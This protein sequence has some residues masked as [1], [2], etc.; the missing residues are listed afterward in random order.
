MYIVS[1]SSQP[2]LSDTFC[3]GDGAEGAGWLLCLFGCSSSIRTA[4]AEIKKGIWGAGKGGG[5]GWV[6]NWGNAGYPKQ[7]G[8]IYEIGDKFLYQKHRLKFGARHDKGG[9]RLAL[10]AILYHSKRDG[11]SGRYLIKMCVY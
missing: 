11:V 2:A 10:L 6:L 5:V 4:V 7:K 3:G 1:A 8:G 9:P